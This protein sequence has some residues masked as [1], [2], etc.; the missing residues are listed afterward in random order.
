MNY[1]FVPKTLQGK[2]GTLNLK[3]LRKVTYPNF[4][5]NN[6]GFSYK[7]NKSINFSFDSNICY[8]TFYY[9]DGYRI[10]A[11][12]KIDDIEN[13]EY[14]VLFIFRFYVEEKDY[15]ELELDYTIHDSSLTYIFEDLLSNNE[16]YLF[17]RENFPT[18]LPINKLKK[19][20]MDSIDDSYEP[21]YKRDLY[22]CITSTSLHN[23]NFDYLQLSDVNNEQIQY[24]RIIVHDNGIKL[25]I[26]SIK[27]NYNYDDY[28]VYLYSIPPS[29]MCVEDSINLLVQLFKKQILK[30]LD[31]SVDLSLVD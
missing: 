25:E 6:L 27:K 8:I 30:N 1:T 17:C 28:E 5:N 31:V 3:E 23:F 18:F 11:V 24:V 9:N 26:N 2:N 10:G 14:P 12:K 20:E 13:S 7:K 15:C 16:K 4:K 22:Y 19:N 21:N 29:T